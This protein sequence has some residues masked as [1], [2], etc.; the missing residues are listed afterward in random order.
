MISFL[1][2]KCLCLNL[3]KR[4]KDGLKNPPLWITA[5]IYRACTDRN[6]HYFV[7]V[8]NRTS[9]ERKWSRVRDHDNVKSAEVMRS[10]VAR[11]LKASGWCRVDV[12]VV[13]S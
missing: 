8:V 1:N 9:K 7:R 3:L 4:V 13:I 12:A 5:F 10:N 11:E 6:I 2:I